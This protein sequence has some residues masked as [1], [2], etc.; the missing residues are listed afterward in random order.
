MPMMVSLLRAR[1]MRGA[2]DVEA[3]AGRGCLDSSL[4]PVR[5]RGRRWNRAEVKGGGPA[6]RTLD[7]G[8]DHATVGFDLPWRSWPGMEYC[9]DP[10]KRGSM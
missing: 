1:F 7:G 5:R 8:R 4:A 6:E 2:Q 10:R 3:R 9:K